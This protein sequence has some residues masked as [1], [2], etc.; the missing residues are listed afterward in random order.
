MGVKIGLLVPERER[1]ISI[2]ADTCE[3]FLLGDDHGSGDCALSKCFPRALP[4]LGDEVRVA[5]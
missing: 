5:V 2:L 4:S 3:I 1:F